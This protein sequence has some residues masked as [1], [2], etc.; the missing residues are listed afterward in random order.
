MWKKATI[1]LSVIISLGLIWGALSINK[2]DSSDVQSS[3][4]TIREE[5]G[6]QYI[7]ILA[8]GGYFPRQ[9]T[10]KANMPTVLELETRGTYDC[11]SALTIPQLNYRKILPATGITKIEVPNDLAINSLDILCGMGMY[12]SVVNFGGGDGT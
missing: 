4:N 6:V 10:A 8:R 12:R 7:R 5:N 9:I 3:V 11:S 1:A 2:N